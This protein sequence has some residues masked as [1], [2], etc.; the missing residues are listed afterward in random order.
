MLDDI[1]RRPV[2]TNRIVRRTSRCEDGSYLVDIKRD[3]VNIVGL[4]D[5]CSATKCYT[6]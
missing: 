6:S 3:V 5:F 2:G 1:V 4:D